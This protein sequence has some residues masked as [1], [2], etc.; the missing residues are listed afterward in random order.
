LAAEA[1]RGEPE[2]QSIGLVKPGIEIIEGHT[3]VERERIKPIF[4]IPLDNG[5]G[6]VGERA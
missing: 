3:R 4:G 1:A 2:L 6:T 5:T